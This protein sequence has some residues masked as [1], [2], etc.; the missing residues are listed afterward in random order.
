[1]VNLT[2]YLAYACAQ[3]IRDWFAVFVQVPRPEN[4]GENVGSQSIET[5]CYSAVNIKRHNIQSSDTTY[6]IKP[7]F[8]VV[9]KAGAEGRGF[10]HS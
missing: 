2:Y 9:E 8:L 7:T 1:M 10:F 3:V 6:S 5:W 4:I